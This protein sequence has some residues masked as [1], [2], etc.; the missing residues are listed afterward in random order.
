M[1]NKNNQLSELELDQI[2]NQRNQVVA[3][4]VSLIQNAR[5]SLSLQEQRFLLYC[6]SKVRPTDDV[7]VEY[8]IELKEFLEVC[9][10]HGSTSY[11]NI[12]NEIMQ[13]LLGMRFQ[14][15]DIHENGD[16]EFKA[17]NW[18]SSLS[19]LY[20]KDRVNSSTVGFQFTQPVA[21]LLTGLAAYNQDVSKE[22]QLYY[23]SD[24]LKYMLPFK[25]RYS[26]YLYPLLRSYQN[27]N[28]WTFPM[29]GPDGLRAL[30]D[31]YERNGKQS[32]QERI[33]QNNARI[34]EEVNFYRK[35]GRAK[36]NQMPHGSIDELPHARKILYPK[37]S[38]F[39]TRVLDPAIKDINTFSNIKVAY[40]PVK[41]GRSVVAVTFIFED[42]QVADRINS[43]KR[44]RVVLDQLDVNEDITVLNVKG[45]ENPL[46]F[47]KAAGT[48]PNTTPESVRVTDK[49]KKT[50]GSFM[51][52]MKE[53]V[54]EHQETMS[55]RPDYVPEYGKHKSRKVDMNGKELIDVTAIFPAEPLKQPKHIGVLMTLERVR[56]YCEQ[57]G[58]RF[59]ELTE[60]ED[61]EVWYF[62][63]VFA[64]ERLGAKRLQQ[65]LENGKVK[66]SLKKE[67]V[68]FD[69]DGKTALVDV[70]RFLR[71]ILADEDE[72]KKL[73]TGYRQAEK[74][75]EAQVN[76]VGL[77]AGENIE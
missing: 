42:K 56:D 43:E 54:A 68:L 52:E 35:N 38:D 15:E 70:E 49:K 28:Q 27:R 16:R 48:G 55:H 53:T 22:K 64:L 12:K 30:L 19:V 34:D 71:K 67:G 23:I 7:N 77:V 5:Y 61:M 10:L 51:E 33:Q 44:G 6:I 4:S 36:R 66:V 20:K 45:V 8:T 40:K 24:E 25:C 58:G 11:D 2:Q 47:S 39:R 65:Y 18:F 74:V 75:M 26:H 69:C 46:E 57:A 31:V 29:E 73:L 50:S 60:I 37:F 1:K 41:R 13:T 59:R 17:I 21:K 32:V 62:F 9:G 76:S 63:L 14:F 72:A 3:R